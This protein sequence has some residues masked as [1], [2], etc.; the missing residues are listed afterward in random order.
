MESFQLATNESQQLTM[1]VTRTEMKTFFGLLLGMSFVRLRRIEDYWSTRLFLGQP[2][3]RRFMSRNR[4]QRI[5]SAPKICRSEDV[6]PQQRNADPLWHFRPLL[7]AFSRK[8]SG[9]RPRCFVCMALGND[10]K[11]LQY[12]SQCKRG[13]HTNCFAVYQHRESFHSRSDIVRDLVKV[14]D[15]ER[16]RARQTLSSNIPTVSNI[17]LGK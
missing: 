13:F 14:D 7:T 11:V 4:F 1:P 6:S 15:Y 17:E 16:N 9:A 12:C 2:D 3:F 10:I 5:R 8:F